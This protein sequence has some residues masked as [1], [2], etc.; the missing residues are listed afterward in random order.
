MPVL[1]KNTLQDYQRSTFRIDSHTRL[2]NPEQAVDF[3]N[4]RGFVFFWPLKSIHFPSLWTAAAGDR[5]VADA[6]DD[7]GHVT[8]GWKD[9]LLGQKRW[10]YAKILRRRGTFLSNQLLPY[11][12]ALSENYGAPEEDYLIQYQEGHLSQEARQVY[13]VLLDRGPLDTI[14]LRKAARLTSHESESHFN[15]ALDQLMSNFNILPVGTCEAGGWHYS[16]LYDT[17]SHQYPKL[18]E[19]ARPI[20]QPVARLEILTWYFNSLGAATAQDIQPLFQWKADLVQ[21]TLDKLLTAGTIRDG[22]ALEGQTEKYHVLQQLLHVK[23]HGM[24]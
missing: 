13:E 18:P 16:Y 7:P 12:Y 1:S 9:S 20:D 22:I 15:K 4:Q 5:P 6:H 8:W 24:L 14:T 3:V 2:R 10:Y 17:V 19:Q 23:T 11:F 21:K